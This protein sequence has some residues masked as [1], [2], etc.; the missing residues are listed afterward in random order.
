[1]ASRLLFPLGQATAKEAFMCNRVFALSFMLFATGCQSGAKEA[2][3]QGSG[4]QAVTLLDMDG[5]GRP[6]AVDFDDDG[7]PDFTIPK[8]PCQKPLIDADG[9]GRPDGVD[10]DCDGKADIKWCLDPLIDADG[11]GRPDGID[12]DCDG[13]ADIPV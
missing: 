4:E 12:L 5:D 1:L 9:D 2:P 7:T 10:F 8:M 3:S 6:D 11:D 13:K